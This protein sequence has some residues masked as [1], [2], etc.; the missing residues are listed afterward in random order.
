MTYQWIDLGDGRSVY[1]KVTD[2]APARSSLAA[3]MVMNDAFDKPTL[4]MADGMLYESKRA[5]SATHKRM[6]YLELGDHKGPAFSPPAPDSSSR[7]SA[8]KTTLDKVGIDPH[9]I[10]ER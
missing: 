1:R 6:G 8:L 2:K 4:C 3:P 10:V 5:M 9:R 7:K